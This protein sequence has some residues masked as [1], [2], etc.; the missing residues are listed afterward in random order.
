VLAA[1]RL[2]GDDTTVPILAKGKT[3]TG[4]ICVYVRD[5]PP[6]GGT[7]PPAAT[8][9]A[10]RDRRQ[11]HPERNLPRSTPDAYNLGVLQHLDEGRP[12]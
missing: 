3:T 12:M 11:A 6:F 5:G 7:A 10:S 9:Y 8:Y 1:E 2:H 4:R